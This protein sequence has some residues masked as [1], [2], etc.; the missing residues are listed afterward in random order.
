MTYFRAFKSTGIRLAGTPFPL[1]AKLRTNQI[2]AGTLEKRRGGE[3]KE[4]SF[5][6]NGGCIIAYFAIVT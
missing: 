5:L 4:E 3:G 6:S 1:M 2:S